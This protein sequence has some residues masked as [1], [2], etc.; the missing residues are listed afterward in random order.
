MSEILSIIQSFMTFVVIQP[1]KV[2]FFGREKWGILSMLDERLSKNRNVENL[3]KIKLINGGQNIWLSLTINGNTI[4]PTKC[5]N[6]RLIC[7]NH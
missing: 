7:N 4:I 6:D 3:F 2:K 5:A 1:K